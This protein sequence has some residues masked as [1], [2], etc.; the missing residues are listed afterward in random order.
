MTTPD[1]PTADPNR[2]HDC[3][4]LPGRDH[5]DRCQS[6]AARRIRRLWDREE[7]LL[8]AQQRSTRQVTTP[9]EPKEDPK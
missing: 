9:E 8:Q 2:C 4:I 3:G 6:P 1:L 7:A 5:L